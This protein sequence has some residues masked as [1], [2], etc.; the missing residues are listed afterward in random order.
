M[1]EIEWDFLRGI[2]EGWIPRIPSKEVSST[3]LY[4]TCYDI[5]FKTNDDM[6]IIHEFPDPNSIDLSNW[7]G[8]DT[9]DDVVLSHGDSLKVD[10][11]HPKA[12]WNHNYLYLLCGIIIATI[13][14]IFNSK[15]KKRKYYTP[16]DAV[17]EMTV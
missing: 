9:D 5:I 10:H 3:D 2:K 8:F 7:Q 14:F 4:G 11:A 15:K 1:I 17:Y 6:S 12:A 16:I 13:V